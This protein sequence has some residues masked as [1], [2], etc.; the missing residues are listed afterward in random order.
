LL[1]VAE[2]VLEVIGRS[3]FDVL[4]TPKLGVWNIGEVPLLCNDA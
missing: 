2:P 4:T 1:E 3:Q